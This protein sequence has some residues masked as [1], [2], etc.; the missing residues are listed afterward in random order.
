MV[1]IFKCVK[2]KEKYSQEATAERCCIK[3]P[4]KYQQRNYVKKGYPPKIKTLDMDAYAKAYYLKNI[5]KIKQKYQDNKEAISEKNKTQEAKDKRNENRRLARE[6]KRRN[7][8][9][10]K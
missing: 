4:V 1:T 9:I 5:D 2:C 6:K 7:K 10:N 3:K 8:D